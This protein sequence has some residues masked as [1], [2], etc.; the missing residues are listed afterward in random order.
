MGFSVIAMKSGL[1][2]QILTMCW[3]LDDAI[4]ANTGDNVKYWML[5]KRGNF[6]N[7]EKGEII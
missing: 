4:P 3:C 7:C 6:E 2:E 1:Y 5:R